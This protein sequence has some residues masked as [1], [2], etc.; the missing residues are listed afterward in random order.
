M[1][2]WSNK[3]LPQHII[4]VL[5]TAQV[6]FH[7]DCIKYRL[8]DSVLRFREVFADY[9]ILKWWGSVVCPYLFPPQHRTWSQSLA[10]V[11][12]SPDA[13]NT[14]LRLLPLNASS[15][16]WCSLLRVAS[17]FGTSSLPSAFDPQHF[18]EPYLLAQAWI[19]PAA[20]IVAPNVKSLGTS[21][22][23]K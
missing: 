19:D 16:S 15:V 1:F 3:L 6:L 23:L 17:L 5:F 13:S 20:S 18:T 7:P 8:F 11:W 4:L 9:S 10:Q 21:V 2:N 22:W 12:L 14:A